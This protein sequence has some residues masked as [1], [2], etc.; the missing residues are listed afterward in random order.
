MLNRVFVLVGV[1]LTL[2]GALA[3]GLSWQG[4]L[5]HD[6]QL[7]INSNPIVVDALDARIREILA[8][9][10]PVEQGPDCLRRDGPCVFIGG[11][12]DFPNCPLFESLK[13]CRAV[14]VRSHLFANP[15]VRDVLE[16]ESAEFCS[17]SRAPVA[18]EAFPTTVRLVGCRSPGPGYSL[19][20]RESPT[21][22]VA[23]LGDETDPTVIEVFAVKAGRRVNHYWC[24]RIYEHAPHPES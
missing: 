24:D 21:L 7:Q 20:H 16:R 10:A 19:V 15:R 12:S 18:P 14:S 23:V 22:C 6:R 2:A 8:V 9:S 1:A 17:Y 5:T 13:N 3:W 4:V 11:V